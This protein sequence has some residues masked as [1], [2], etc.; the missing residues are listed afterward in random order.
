MQFLRKALILLTMVASAMIMSGC[1]ASYNRDFLQEPSSMKTGSRILIVT[2]EDGKFEEDIYFDS[3]KELIQVLTKQLQHYTTNISFIPNTV[4][5]N[6]INDSQ[7]QQ[8]D[9]VIIPKI[10]HWED[11]ATGWSF[12]PD[13]IKI[14]FDIFDNQRNSINSVDITGKSASLVWVQKTPKSL[15][16]KPISKMLKELFQQ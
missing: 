2:P 15:L 8:F 7:L 10:L 4:T 3:A 14:H 6:D 1:T 16:P 12:R 13:R 5:I 9:Y 11:R